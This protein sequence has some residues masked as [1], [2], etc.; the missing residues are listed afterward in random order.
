MSIIYRAMKFAIRAHGDQK[1]GPYPYVYHLVMV[2]EVLNKFG[3]YAE[4]HRAAAYL[5]DILEDTKITKE[6]LEKEF[7]LTISSLVY[8]VT[9][10][11]GKNRKEKHE[12]TYPKIRTSSLATVLKIAD[13]IANVR[14]SIETES[15]LL[16]MYKEEHEEFKK[17]LQRGNECISMWDE[18]DNLLKGNG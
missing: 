1:Y 11:P 7:G 9:N 13:R 14:F 3:W 5:H 15:P 2:D 18:L 8:L 4:E 10:E 16:K 17:I 12:K 6:E